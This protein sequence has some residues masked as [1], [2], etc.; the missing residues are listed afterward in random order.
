M[1]VHQETPLIVPPGK[2]KGCLYRATEFGRVFAP[3]QDRVKLLSWDEIRERINPVLSLR[4]YVKQILDQGDVG[5]CA[6]EATAQAIMTTRVKAGMPHVLLNPW[7]IYQQTSGGRDRG[8]SIDDNLRFAQEHGCLPEAVWPRSKGWRA[9]PPPD[10]WRRF[11]RHFRLNEVYEIGETRE[12]ATALVEPYAAVFGWE[13]HSCMLDE[14]FDE[15]MAGYANSW[16]PTWGDKGFGKIR[17]R[18]INY[19]YGQFAV[20]TTTICPEDILEEITAYAN[21]G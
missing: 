6:A 19:G 10:L 13:G 3:M 1:I 11:G 20:R 21:A 14:L 18:S 17:L 8:S 4:P 16:D 9:V 12:T 7:S 15:D 2:K 5:S